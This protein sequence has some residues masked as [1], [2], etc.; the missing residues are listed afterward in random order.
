MHF[1]AMG[2]MILQAIPSYDLKLVLLSD[3]CAVALS[4]SALW[5]TFHP[6]A[7]SIVG[8]SVR[9]IGSAILVGIAIDGMHYIAMAGV[10]FQPAFKPIPS[11]GISNYVLAITIGSATLI[12]MMLALV[13]SFLVSAL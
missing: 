13:A 10:S 11:S 6:T 2:G 8:E 3:L 7:K 5:L 12:I 1:T 9:R 4:L